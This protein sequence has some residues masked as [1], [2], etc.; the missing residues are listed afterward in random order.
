MVLKGTW[1]RGYPDGRPVCDPSA[2]RNS[3]GGTF[4]AGGTSLLGDPI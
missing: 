1:M 3:V 2:V 4:K